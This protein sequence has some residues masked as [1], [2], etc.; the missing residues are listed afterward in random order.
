MA[1]RPPS[2]P[3]TLTWYT[4]PAI[5]YTLPAVALRTSYALPAIALHSPRYRSLLQPYT[6]R[7]TAL[8]SVL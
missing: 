3:K 4:L 6:L 2:S 5:A 7:A 8:Q 1:S